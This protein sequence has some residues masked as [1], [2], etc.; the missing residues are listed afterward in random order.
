MSIAGIGTSTGTQV[1]VPVREYDRHSRHEYE[2]DCCSPPIVQQ[3]LVASSTGTQ[4]ST[5]EVL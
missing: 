5:T 1:R 3:Y 2:Y 4:S